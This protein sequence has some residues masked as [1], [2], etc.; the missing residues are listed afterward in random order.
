MRTQ[1][2]AVL[3]AAGSSTRMGRI[4]QLLPLSDGPV[5][6][7]CLRNIIASGIKDIV[8][9][10][11]KNSPELLDALRGFPVWVAINNTSQSEMADSVRTG[12]GHIQ[13]SST[14]VLVCLSDQPLVSVETFKSLKEL[15]CECPDKII[16]PVCNGKKGH[17]TI[18]PPSTLK[19]IFPDLT[20]RQI[21]T[22]DPGRVRYHDLSDEGTI[23]DMD[24]ME[25]YL[26]VLE[27]SEKMPQPPLNRKEFKIH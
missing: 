18:F 26:K 5:I 3:L 27:K 13:A 25:D 17:P 19:E 22:R 1:V 8:V 21:I 9:V 10:L 2:S 4:K 24:T 16:I 6:N 12:L 7:Y 23:I 11:G 20:L 15:H 14:G